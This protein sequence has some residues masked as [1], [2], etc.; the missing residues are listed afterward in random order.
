MR[1]SSF[2]NNFQVTAFWLTCNLTENKK[3]TATDVLARYTSLSTYSTQTPRLMESEMAHEVRILS[4]ILM[5][6]V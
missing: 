2:D 4:L 1:M 6:V 3:I 5:G